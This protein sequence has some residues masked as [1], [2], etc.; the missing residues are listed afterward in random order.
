MPEDDA[1]SLLLE[2]E[3]VHL[4]AEAS[5]IALLGLLE[6]L[7]VVVELFLGRPCGRVDAGQ[8]RVFGIAAPIGARHLHELEGVA[9][10]AGRGHV[11]TAA[12][13]EP[14]ALGID[15]EI[16]AFGNR[17]NQLDLVGLAFLLEDLASL[18]AAPHFLGEGFVA[19]D[20]LPH[21]RLDG[22]EIL[23]GEG[24]VAGEVVIEAVLDHRT[25]GHLRSREKLLHRFCEHMR[26]IVPDQLQR[27][28][29]LAVEELDPGILGDRIGQIRH[30]A[31]EGHGDRAL[32][33]GLGNAVHDLPAGDAGIVL[34]LGAIGKCQGN[35]QIFLLAHSCQRSR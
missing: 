26:G 1:R 23:R 13:V 21:L 7:Q 31:V 27:A 17:V 34:A 4:A 8:H 10:L 32:G 30:G 5:V 9:D 14:V 29:V 19:R 16:L 24:L 3:Q 33:K 18:V 25:D 6:L 2:M 28:R 35:H 15:L 20:D 11:R 22:G 12:Q